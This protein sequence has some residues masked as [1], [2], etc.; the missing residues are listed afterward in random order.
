MAGND[1]RIVVVADADQAKRELSG[2]EG[3]AK[4]VGGAF[5]DMAKIAGGFVIGQALTS[6]PGHFSN[7]VGAASN[8]NEALSKSNTI[9]GEN[10]KEIEKWASGAATDFGQSKSAALDAAGSFGNMFTQ[11][12]IGTDVAADM[13]MAMVELASDFASFHNADI[14]EVVNAQSA[15]FRGEYDALQRFVPTINAAAV[16]TEA[17]AMTG[18]KLTEELTIQEKALAVNALMMKGAGDAAGDFD[19]T[20]DGAANKARILDA[21]MAD[22]SAT[23]GQ[24]LLPIKVALMGVLLDKVIPGFE[25]LWELF[26]TKVLPVLEDLAKKVGDKV[27]PIIRGIGTL[28]TETIIPAIIDFKDKLITLATAGL[29]AAIPKLKEFWDRLKDIDFTQLKADLVEVKDK[30]EPMIAVLKPLVED[31]LKAWKTA[32]ED[33]WEAMKPLTEEIKKWEPVLKPLGILIGSVIVVVLVALIVQLRIA[34]EVIRV[35]LIVAITALTVALE[36][37]R[38]TVGFVIDVFKTLDEKF[39]ILETTIWIVREAVYAIRDAFFAV[40]DAVW[41]VIHAIGTLIAKINVIPSVPDISPGFDVPGVPGFASGG[42]VPGPVGK[43]MLAVVHGGEEVRTLEQQGGS[44]GKTQ[45]IQLVVDGEV[46]AAA[47]ARYDRNGLMK[48][49]SLG[50][51]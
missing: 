43:P 21:R 7:A 19:R 4:K 30:L 48:S 40:R 23:I 8:L 41:E 36:S 18:K 20:S 2:L 1:V 33:V 31:L 17:L 5:G 46:L 14:T 12:G 11:L 24:K 38:V 49:R 37:V 26:T 39:G 15:A 3:A 29:D 9:F 34:A 47:L 25:T 10:G 22:L 35:G 32:I 6:L 27:L 50:Y 44:T 28:I 13:S 42:I 51:A 45:I 16:E